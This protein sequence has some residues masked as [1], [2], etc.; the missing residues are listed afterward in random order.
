MPAEWYDADSASSSS[1]RPTSP[2][3]YA[4][5]MRAFSPFGRPDV[6]GPA[7]TKIAGRWPNDRA[8]MSMPGT[9]L[10]QTPSIRLASNMSCES[11]SAVDI[12]ITSRLNSESCMPSRPWVM[13]SHIAGTPPANWAM[14][15]ERRTAFFIW[16]GKDSKGWWAE[17]MSLY[18]DTIATL[19]LTLPRSAALSTVSEAAKPWARLAQASLVRMGP[20]VAAASSRARYAERSVRL[21]STIRAVTSATTEFIG[22]VMVSPGVC[23]FTRATSDRRAR[24]GWWRRRGRS[25][26]R[27]RDGARARAG[28]TARGRA[29]SSARRP[30]PRRAA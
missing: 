18:A 19:G 9:I 26:R 27:G 11:A 1:S 29:R 4:W 8:P 10:S 21:R 16:A 13:P 28:P 17:S 2:A 23:G 24:S 20:R 5:R 7:G 30:R 14:P 22:W 6:I 15:P 25:C 3:A 12:A